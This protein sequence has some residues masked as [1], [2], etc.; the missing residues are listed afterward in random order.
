MIRNYSPKEYDNT[1]QVWGAIQDDQ[2]L[3]YFGMTNGGGIVEYDGMEWRVIDIPNR[4]TVFSF[5]KDSRGIIFTGA[6]NDFGYLRRDSLGK[7]EFVSL[8]HFIPDQ[9]IKFRAVWQTI[10]VNDNVYFMSVEALFKYSTAPE[11]SIKIYPP[12]KGSSFTGMFSC[13]GVVYVHQSDRGLMRITDDH[14]ELASDFYGDKPFRKGLPYGK[15]SALITTRTA[16]IYLY[17]PRSGISSLFRIRDS[18][19]RSGLNIYTST[20]LPGGYFTL[21]ILGKGVYLVSPAGIVV[22]RWNE[23]NVLATNSV[24]SMTLTANN[25]LWFMTEDGIART[26]GSRSWSCWNKTNGLHGTVSDILRYQNTL[27]IA[28]FSGVYFLDGRNRMEA[29][30]GLP[31]GQCWSLLDFTTGRGSHRLLAGTPGGIYEIRGSTSFPIRRGRYGLTMVR[32]RLDPKRLFVV[33]DPMLASIRYENGRWREE[34]VVSGVRDNIRRIV[35][36][37]NGNLWLGT[38]NAGVIKVTM[39]KKNIVKPKSVRYYTQ[40]E[41]LPSLRTVLPYIIHNEIVFATEKG[42]SI[43]NNGTD[44]FA[45]YGKIHPLL[46]DGKQ[47][48]ERIVETNDGS[49]IVFPLS[50]RNSDPGILRPLRNGEFEWNYKP[51]RRL[52][53]TEF[54]AVHQ[55]SDGVLWIGT[56]DGLFRYDWKSDSR[57][58]EAGFR[59]LIRKVTLDND[60]VI[61]YGGNRFDAVVPYENNDVRFDVA[62]PFFDDESKTVFSYELNG[63]DKSWSPWLSNPSAVY[64]NL[65]EGTYVFRAKAKNLYDKESAAAEFTLTVLPPWFRS[66]WAYFS[67]L[68]FLILSVATFDRWNRKRLKR[69]HDRQYEEERQQQ[70]KLS[71][72]LI[73][74]QENER[75]R[76]ARE[77]HDGIGQ[78]LLILKHQLQLKLREKRLNRALKRMLEE[79]S[80]ATSNVIAEVRSISHDLRPPELDRLGVTETIKSILARIRNTKKIDIIGEIDAIDGFF[81][82]DHEINIIRIIQETMNNI[83]KHAHAT[84]A[85]IRLTRALD[86][87]DLTIS[88]NGRGMSGDAGRKAGLGMTDIKERVQLL[89]GTMEIHSLIG[90]GTTFHFHFSGTSTHA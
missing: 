19:A 35:E 47:D 83:L 49:I 51:F 63:Y 71:Q 36:D 3:M 27:Y 42:L 64:T 22:Q 65:D 85:T 57:D 21:S 62:A 74:R 69:M 18:S 11:P 8:R 28:T 25:N 61:S 7:N 87:V 41:G 79:Q 86:A 14:L 90:K 37:A 6:I 29:V 44:T 84:T 30:S 82:Q 12:E 24:Y 54:N 55:D 4:T 17:R 88:D 39:D 60:S 70:H 81:Q 26:E 67:Y 34:G 33:D 16:G 48:I 72:M 45:P 89:G 66:W 23:H 50:N 52:R 77:M 75:Q 32:S 58:Y 9:S 13:G 56:T 15:D 80:A 43:Y 10:I 5:A 2:G 53:R 31:P 76:I 73:E 38:Y 1:P 78:E 68:L 20:L 40:K 59:T 46:S